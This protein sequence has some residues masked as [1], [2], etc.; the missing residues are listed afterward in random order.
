M[1]INEVAFNEKWSMVIMEKI[2]KLSILKMN[3]K[4]FSSEFEVSIYD[5]ILF[6]YCSNDENLDKIY[7]R[8]LQC[9]FLNPVS[10]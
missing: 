1:H 9:L 2:S 4:K 10:V 5:I 6:V 3:V 8:Q 7:D